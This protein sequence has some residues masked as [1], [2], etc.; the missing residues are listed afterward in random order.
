P[1]AR[2]TFA[3]PRPQNGRNH[4]RH[5]PKNQPGRHT[6]PPRRTKRL[7]GPLHLPHRLRPRNRFRH[8]A[9]HRRRTPP[10]PRHPPRLP[11]RVTSELSVA[12]APIF[13][14]F[15][16][17]FERAFVK[18]FFR[19]LILLFIFVS[20]SLQSVD[21]APSFSNSFLAPKSILT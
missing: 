1:H 17:S 12:A 20:F 4:F 13:C 19:K 7:E 21:A 6:D 16:N 8:A 2:R 18:L 15:F 9:R 11:R 3:R 5:H 14:Y 10:K